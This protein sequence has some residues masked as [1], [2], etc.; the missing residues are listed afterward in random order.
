MAD[1]T[2]VR[3]PLAAESLSFEDRIREA[4]AR[5]AEGNDYFR[6]GDWQEALSTYESAIGFLP[7]K[8][9]EDKRPDTPS[10]EADVEEDV[11]SQG[12]QASAGSAGSTQ[13]DPDPETEKACSTLRSVLNANIGAC[14]V[15]SGDHKQAVEA[16][17]RA[18]LDDPKYVKALQRRVASNEILDTWSSLSSAQED[19]NT[20]LNL[21]PSGPETRDT[22]SKIQKL[23]PRLEAAQK[24][25]TTEMLG[26]LKTLGNSILGNFGLSTDNFQFEPNGQGG[27]SVNFK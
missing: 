7:K 22:Q 18:L 12:A 10:R 14:H 16:C 23:K 9:T 26:K 4:N 24:R 1:N 17:T 6:K 27:Y 15:K 19:Y 21:L 8:K 2:F 11:P 13:E 20:L 3:I 25:E 5:K